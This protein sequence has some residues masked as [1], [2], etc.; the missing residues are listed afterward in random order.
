MR[1]LAAD[2]KTMIDSV[3]DLTISDV[4]N[5]IFIFF[6]LEFPHRLLMHGVKKSQREILI[7]VLDVN[8]PRK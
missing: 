2:K 5:M 6:S 3:I 7:S 1:C 8:E 4:S